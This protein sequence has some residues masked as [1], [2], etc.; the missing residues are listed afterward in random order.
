LRGLGLGAAAFL[1]G[2][3]VAVFA[4]LV[5]ARLPAGLALRGERAR[6]AERL[7]LSP[8]TVLV[9]LAMGLVWAGLVL[10][11]GFRPDLAAFLALGTVL[12]I[13]SAIDLEHHRLPNRVLGPASIL[14][15][16]L[17]GMAAL[18]EG[19]WRPLASAGIGALAYGVPILALALIAPGE[20][21]AG[22]IKLAAYLGWHLGWLGLAQVLAG[23]LVG[24]VAGG[25]VGAALLAT[26]RKKGKDPIPFGPFM[27]LG[28]LAVVLGLNPL[29]SLWR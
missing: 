7:R 18:A 3:T 15:V 20:M 9:E 13:L 14:A 10:R 27:A 29:E 21:G 26:R 11:I 8:R 6:D 16:V 12:V 17:L 25:V 1:A 2:L 19:N 5:V 28:A 23:M 24:F 4:N 22:D